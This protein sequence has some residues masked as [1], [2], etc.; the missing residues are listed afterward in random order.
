VLQRPWSLVS[1]TTQLTEILNA[2]AYPSLKLYFR[3]F[4]GKS[5]ATVIPALLSVGLR[6]VWQG[7][8][9]AQ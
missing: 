2:R 6:S 7:D 1:T 5:H 4:E 8:F 9:A 3:A